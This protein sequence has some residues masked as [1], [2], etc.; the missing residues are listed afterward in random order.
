MVRSCKSCIHRQVCEIYDV[1]N[2]PLEAI[3]CVHF[4]DAAD[5][6]PKSEEGAECP[7]CHGTGRIGTTDWLT[8]NISKKQLA[9]E[10]AQAIAEHEQY[11]KAEYA[12]EIFGEIEQ[13]LR[14][15]F[16]FFRQD[17][18]I[19]ESSAIVLAISEIAELKKKHGV[20]D[21]N[22]GNKQTEGKT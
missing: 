10:K 15:L 19:R 5:V 21:T 8:K 22:V 20:T 2:E 18:C 14:G 17:D 12:R 13:Q 1:T 7:T 4:L 3:G 16:D 9:E 11:I 6:V